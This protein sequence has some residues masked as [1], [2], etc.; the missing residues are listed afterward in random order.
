MPGCLSHALS[1]LR[2]KLCTVKG[3][4]EK[5][6][7]VVETRDGI[8]RQKSRKKMPS[9]VKLKMELSFPFLSNELYIL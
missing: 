3:E 6:S 4:S 7:R 9:F 8:I 5:K 1:V 2:S